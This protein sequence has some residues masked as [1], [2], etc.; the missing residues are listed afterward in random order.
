MTGLTDIHCHVLPHVDDGAADTA[1]ALEML[2]IMYDEGIDNAILTPHYHGGHMET[3]IDK[4]KDR[5]DRLCAA[6]AQDLALK[7]MKLYL[8]CEIYYYPSVIEW[9]EEGRVSSMAGSNYVL[10]EFGY[11][12]DKRAISDGITQVVNSG[13][14]PIIAHVERY[15][16]LV[17]DL[18]AVDALVEKGAYIQINS[19][20]LFAGHTIRS[21]ARKL[22]KEDMVHFIATDGHDT[23]GRAPLIS[24]AVRYVI[25]H[26]GED[27]CRKLVIDNPQKVIENE[28]ISG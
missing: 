11:T 26:F 22:L 10:L 16:K 18:K 3:G 20:C 23:N 2:R 21:F 1:E 24:D 27:R 8:G 15:D 9:L 19:Q 6:A 12:M 14:F 25:K 28:Y 4:I 7:D 17:G 13:Y 5:F